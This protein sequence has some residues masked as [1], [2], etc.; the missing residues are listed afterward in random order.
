MRTRAYIV[1]TDRLGNVKRLPLAKPVFTIGRYSDNDLPVVSESVSRHHAEIVLE[2]GAYYLID[3]GSKSG[4]FVNGQAVVRQELRNRDR[5]RLGGDHDHGIQFEDARATA[6]AEEQGIRS[7]GAQSSRI[8]ARAELQYLAKFLEVNQAL[9]I[10]LSIDEVLSLIVDAAVE[11]TGAE[12]GALLLPNERGEIEFRVAR[13]RDRRTL[14]SDRFL[15]SWTAV[16]QA[17]QGSRGVIIS[18]FDGQ[19]KV[20][21][22]QSAVQLELR[23]I[24][25][26]PLQRFRI[27]ERSDA[28]GVFSRDVVGTLYVDSRQATG[29]LS[30]TSVTLLES[31]AFEASK[32]LESLR[33]MQEEEQMQRMEREFAMA[34]EVQVALLTNSTLET[35]HVEV[36]A[37]STPSRYVDGDFYDL[38][39]LEDGRS[40]IVLGDVAGKGVGAALLASMS[41]GILE[42]Q[43]RSG[44]SL[45]TVIT[46]L[47]QLLVRKSATDKFVTLFC[48]VLNSA[49]DLGFVN[50]GHNPPILLRA[51]GEIETLS[52]NGLVVGAFDFA[53]YSES[54]TQLLPG[55]VLVVFTDGVTEATGETG[56]MFGDH[57]LVAVLRSAAHCRASEIR[58]SIL[59]TVAAFTQGCPQ[60]DD[61][62]IVALKMKC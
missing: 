9:K 28:T 1:Y 8:N 61:I 51:N 7:E 30:K 53:R 37:K 56:E 52:S 13:D 42:G 54:Q 14:F 2:E 35:D 29:A 23:K 18:D 21:A 16:N 33:L 45:Q 11:I 34:R 57:R 15:I 4:T 43:L 27:R 49:G 62:T 40:V 46:N 50:A 41:Q 48:A 31:L 26:I 36:A 60:E 47:N 58:D 20:E 24:V 17:F 12:R 25:C 59:A 3:K 22:T 10:S 55:D 32:A 38:F 5:I 44:Q 19:R 39:T 6:C